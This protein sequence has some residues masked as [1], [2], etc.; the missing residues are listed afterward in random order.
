MRYIVLRTEVNSDGTV[1]LSSIHQ[2]IRK[3]SGSSIEWIDVKNATTNTID[4][5]KCDFMSFDN[6][7][8]AT[9][10]LKDADLDSDNIVVIGVEVD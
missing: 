7:E 10:F 2:T 8:S 4:P 9:E 1:A 3:S 5:S 6:K